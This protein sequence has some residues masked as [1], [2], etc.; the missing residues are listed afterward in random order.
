MIIPKLKR[1]Y[2]WCDECVESSY[3]LDDIIITGEER[4]DAIKDE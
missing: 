1:N 3:S 2:D 4:L